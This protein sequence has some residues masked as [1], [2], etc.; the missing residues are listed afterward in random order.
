MVKGGDD[1][2]LL[3]LLLYFEKKKIRINCYATH[4]QNEKY[5]EI[6]WINTLGP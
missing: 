2:R 5:L 6:R 4:Y 1:L 3:N